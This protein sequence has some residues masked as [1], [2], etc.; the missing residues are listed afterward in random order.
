MHQHGQQETGAINKIVNMRDGSER[1]LSFQNAHATVERIVGER[2]DRPS[3]VSR[4]ACEIAAEII[5]NIRAPGE[6]L[7]SVELA[8]HYKTSRTPVR[9]AL[10]LLEKEGLVTVPPRRRPSV[11]SFDIKEVREIYNVRA[12]LLGATAAD[13]ARRASVEELAELRMHLDA[14]CAAH[15]A[16][17][18]DDYVWANVAFYNV[19]TVA[20]DNQTAKRII[21]SL[22]LRT[23]RLRRL[24]LS[25]PSRLDKS[26]SSHI[27]ILDA[28]EEHDEQLA[29]A[30][31]LSNHLHSLRAL[32]AYF[33]ESQPAAHSDGTAVT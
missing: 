29:S 4:I 7:N 23:L 17:H 31:I 6:D 21:D 33:I 2:H 30:L 27:L 32:E 12:S 11:A 10:M 26:I 22:L 28:C 15:E 3:L 19:L 16:G 9:E 1:G 18:L 14:M 25:L 8:R 13:V 24:S 20:A 5:E